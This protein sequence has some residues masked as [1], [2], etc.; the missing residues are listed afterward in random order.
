MQ[1]YSPS[2]FENPK[3][4]IDVPSAWVGL[5][6]ILSDIMDRFSVRHKTAL[7]F[8]VEYGYSTVALSNY[9]EQVVG[10]DTFKGDEHTQNGEI[11]FDKVAKDLSPYT[12]QLLKMDYREFIKLTDRQFDLIHVDIV[13]T[14][15][16]TYD[17]GEWSV[18]HA[19]IV[20]FHDT[21]SYP[22]VKKAV[23]DLA[24]RHGLNFY[25]YPECNGLGILCRN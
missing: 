6:T 22:Q 8:G 19:P 20:L 21:E 15:E 16:D 9:F 23:S 7:E 17:C 2:K 5:E 1:V 24:R 11:D 12:I 4:L 25:N 3:N 13:H 14:Y 18:Y 10:V